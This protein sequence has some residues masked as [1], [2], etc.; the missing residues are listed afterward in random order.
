MEVRLGSASLKSLLGQE[1]LVFPTLRVYNA[2]YQLVF[3]FEGDHKDLI[4]A[5]A[6]SLGNPQPIAGSRLTRWIPARRMRI[7]E[8]QSPAPAWIFVETWAAW[9]P[10][11]MREKKALFRFFAS[12]ALGPVELVLVKMG[13]LHFHGHQPPRDLGVRGSRVL[14]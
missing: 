8:Q 11:C 4:G 12:H 9:D 1:G 6:Y 13:T 3:R 14:S 5:L 10:A 2:K 7:L